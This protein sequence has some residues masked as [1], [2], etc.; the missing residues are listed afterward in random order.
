MAY[1]I[2][3]LVSDLLHYA[4]PLPTGPCPIASVSGVPGTKANRENLH[5][6][7]GTPFSSPLSRTFDGSMLR[8]IRRIYTNRQR[9]PLDKLPL[10]DV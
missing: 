10:P 1:S 2:S 6:A 5:S 7:T 8:E 3:F 4:V 9:P